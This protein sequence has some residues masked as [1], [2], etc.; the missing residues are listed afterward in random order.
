MSEVRDYWRLLK[1]NVMS[2]VVFSAGVGL[3][4]APGSLHPVIAV[5]AVMCIASGAGASAAINNSYDADIDR[6]MAR[7]RKRPTALGVI[8]P[9]DALAFG[10]TLSIIS[11]AVMGLAVNWIA[12]SLLALTIGFYV[13]VYT[14]WLKRRTPQNIVI[15]GAAG[16]LPPMV[17]WA[18]VTGDVSLMPVVLFAIIFFWTPPHFWALA[19]YR[20]QDYAAA[21]VPMLPVTAGAA[22]TRRHIL[23]YTLVLL[24]ITWLPLIIGE[25]GLLYG[26]VATALGAGFIGHAVQLLKDGTQRLATKT[27]RFSI[28]YLFGV[29]GALL[30][31]DMV[32]RIMPA[33]PGSLG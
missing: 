9:A 4:L 14:M 7:T 25:A 6:V 10:V 3:Y 32:T 5:I 2:L 13:I 28:L 12:A 31:D 26:L 16:A 19:L 29:F 23:A 8:D 17:G 33:L 11:I 15:G 20:A 1:P 30:L 22:V 18:A 21:G 24:P 27:F